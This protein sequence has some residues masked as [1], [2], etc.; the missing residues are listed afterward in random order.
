MNAYPSKVDAN[1]PEI[2]AALRKA[3]ASVQHLHQV[4]HGCPDIAVGYGGHTYLLEIKQP[5]KHLTPDE[6]EWHERWAGHA[7]IVTCVREALDVIGA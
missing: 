1:Q 6:R 4:G 2:V 5:G 7:T 3:G